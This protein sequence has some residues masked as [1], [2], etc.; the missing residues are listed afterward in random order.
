VL[1]RDLELLKRNEVRWGYWVRSTDPARQFLE[2]LRRFDLAGRARPF[3]RCLRCN[4]PLR[5]VEKAEVLD[6]LPPRTRAEFDAF[7]VCNSCGRVYWRGSHYQR[8]RRFLHD[9]LRT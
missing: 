4:D 9:S 8:L 2:V 1:T 7:H 5:P 3:S 6:R